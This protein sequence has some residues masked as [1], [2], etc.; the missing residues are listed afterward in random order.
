MKLRCDNNSR[1]KS[2]MSCD[3]VG[4]TGKHSPRK[5]SMSERRMR[6]HGDSSKG[7]Q[8]SDGRQGNMFEKEFTCKVR[9][10]IDNSRNEREKAVQEWSNGMQRVIKPEEH[11]REARER[12][13]MEQEDSKSQRTS[14][15]GEDMGS[16]SP[17]L[18]T[19]SCGRKLS[20]DV[21]LDVELAAMVSSVETTLYFQLYSASV[22]M[23]A[24]SYAA[25]SMTYTPPALS[26][27]SS[28]PT[29]SAAPASV[30]VRNQ[31]PRQRRATPCPRRAS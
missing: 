28:L 8:G 11:K 27:S 23:S 30:T 26:Y 10:A 15:M 18:V 4:T 14:S 13:R 20:Q 17:R 5:K 29:V 6:K 21:R 7:C 3:E 31:C 1:V 25:S 9:S 19:V 16:A 22:S 2:V 24:A 12:M